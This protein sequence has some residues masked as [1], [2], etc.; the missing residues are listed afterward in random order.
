MMGDVV[1]LLFDMEW[2]G[3]PRDGV[4]WAETFLKWPQPPPLPGLPSGSGPL[5]G[6]HTYFPGT[7]FGTN[8][9]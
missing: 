5:Q 9:G 3:S 4:Y 8:G 1:V 7:F 6:G 2:V